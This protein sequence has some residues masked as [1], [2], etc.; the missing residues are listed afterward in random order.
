MKQGTFLTILGLALA[1]SAIAA[2]ASTP[3]FGPAAQATPPVA[4]P[5]G[6]IP[7]TASAS[8]MAQ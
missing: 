7:P 8:P 2:A 5:S 3:V 4:T 1:A 6:V